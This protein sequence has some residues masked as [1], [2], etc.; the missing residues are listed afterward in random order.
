V[1]LPVDCVLILTTNERMHRGKLFAFY[2][3]SRREVGKDASLFNGRRRKPSRL[4]E[5]NCGRGG[6]R[7]HG[8]FYS[9]LDFES[10]ALD[11]TQPP[12]HLIFN[13][14]RSC[15]RVVRFFLQGEILR[16][17]DQWS[18]ANARELGKSA[19]GMPAA[20]PGTIA[21]RFVLPEIESRCR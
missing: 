18:N 2:R 21:E 12:F 6:I 11:R 5:G 14:L 13:D 19:V 7:T 16:P 1:V 20:I 17:A 9:T 4:P 3:K 10:S 15:P 8:A